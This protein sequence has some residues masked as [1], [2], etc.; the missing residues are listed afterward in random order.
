MNEKSGNGILV[1]NTFTESL[2]C[3]SSTCCT[4][5]VSISRCTATGKRVD[6]ILTGSSMLTWVWGAVV[7]VWGCQEGFSNI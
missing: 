6:P 4:H 1:Q 2:R 5:G 7:Y 3:V